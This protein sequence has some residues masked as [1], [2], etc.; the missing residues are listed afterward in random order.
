MIARW[1]RPILLTHSRADGD[2]LGCLIAMRSMLAAHGAQPTG[3]MFEPATAKYRWFVDQHPIDIWE[4]NARPAAV[5]HADGV[6]VMDTCT[7]NQLQPATEWLHAIRRDGG[8]P[9][10]AIDH[11]VTRDDLADDYLVD[12]S[13]AATCAML[14]ELSQGCLWSLGEPA[15][16]ALY[17]GLATD[18][19]WFRFSNTDARALDIA[20]QLVCRGIVPNVLYDRLY[21]SESVERVRLFATALESIELLEE[22]QVAVMAIPSEMF[23]R[24]GASPADTEDLINEAMR[25]G[26]VELAVL[27]VEQA[28]DSSTPI[29][30]SF[31]SRSRVDVAALARRFGGGG[32]VRAA[33]ARISGSIAS[34]KQRILGELATTGIRTQRS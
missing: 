11:H 8:I 23:A 9:I 29:K 31:R 12:E 34:V 33:G 17:V 6:L 18:T 13:A 5:D 21:Q 20:A 28:E 22:D 27:I 25:I 19:G 3:Y 7:Y 24:T 15:L 1:R 30:V 14:Y 10:V 4:A 26:S 32:H 16:T 2:A